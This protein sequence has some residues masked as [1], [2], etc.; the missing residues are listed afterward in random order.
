MKDGD[1]VGVAFDDGNNF[2][3]I[4]ADEIVEDVVAEN[5]IAVDDKFAE[6][7][8]SE[9]GL[10]AVYVERVKHELGELREQ[11]SFVVDHFVHWKHYLFGTLLKKT[12]LTLME[13]K[14]G[15]NWSKKEKR[16][17]NFR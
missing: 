17:P 11:G 4:V 12:P 5:G 13:R 1:L 2:D 14:R 16:E 10:D 8:S 6:V 15:W 7:K 9:V 3:N